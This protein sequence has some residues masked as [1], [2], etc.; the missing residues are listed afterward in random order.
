MSRIFFFV[1]F[2]PLVSPA[3]EK[4]LIKA[5]SNG[6]PSVVSY[7]D[8]LKRTTIAYSKAGKEIFRSEST[9]HYN[10]SCRFHYFENNQ[11]AFVKEQCHPDG[12]IQ[13]YEREVTFDTAG[14]QRTLIRRNYNGFS[15]MPEESIECNPPRN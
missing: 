4:R 5:F 14:V 12:G 13:R 2:L 11:I 10:C 6:E 1:L 15:S 8:G 9:F 7:E 3:Q